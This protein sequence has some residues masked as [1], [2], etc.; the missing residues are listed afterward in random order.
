MTWHIMQT[1]KLWDAWNTPDDL[2]RWDEQGLGVDWDEG[3]NATP[4]W[5]TIWTIL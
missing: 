4:W 5:I 2:N 3:R 1:S